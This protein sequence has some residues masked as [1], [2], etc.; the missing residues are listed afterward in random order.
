MKLTEDKKIELKEA[1][2]KTP[3]KIV[4]VKTGDEEHDFVFKPVDR[5]TVDISSKE[6]GNSPTKSVEIEM[7]NS[8]VFGDKSV[9]EKD[10]TVFVA[11]MKKWGE[12]QKSTNVT[13]TLGEL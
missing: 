4:T 1:Y 3:L 6:A 11:L 9:I 8:L 10:D 2:P 13:V 12:I 7:V 5:V